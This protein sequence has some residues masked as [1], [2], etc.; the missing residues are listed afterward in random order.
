MKKAHISN[1]L[2]TPPNY[3]HSAEVAA[4]SILFTAGAVPLD[5][6]GNLL[7]DGDAQEQARVVARNLLTVLRENQYELDNVVKTT[8]YVVGEDSNVLTQ[9]WKELE[10]QGLASSSIPSTLLGVSCLGYPGQL[11]EVEAI[12]YR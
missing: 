7:G 2:F 5:G 12:A 6:E 11:V 10:V 3:A 9:V 8:V 1:T 4:S